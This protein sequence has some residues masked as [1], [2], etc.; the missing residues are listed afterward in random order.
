MSATFPYKDFSQAIDELDRETD[1]NARLWIKEGRKAGLWGA[2]SAMV[3][4]F[5]R[6]YF[7]EGA[8]RQ[9]VRGLFWAVHCGMRPFLSYAKYWELKRD[10]K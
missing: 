1:E 10:R 5:G 8:R 4:D 7:K 2:L 6:V 3:R 9:G